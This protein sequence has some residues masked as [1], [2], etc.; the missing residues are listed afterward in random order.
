MEIVIIFMLVISQV[1]NNMQ[2]RKVLTP[3]TFAEKKIE[4]N[5]LII[6]FFLE[7]SVNVL[8]CNQI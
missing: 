6:I 8:F 7:S 3:D 1:I 5:P 4:R 2:P